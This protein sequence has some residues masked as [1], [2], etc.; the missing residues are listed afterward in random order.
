LH[1]L[2]CLDLAQVD[3]ACGGVVDVPTE[4]SR[5]ELESAARTGSPKLAEAAAAATA[6]E[7]AGRLTQYL[8]GVPALL[9]RY[10]GT[11]G[12]PYG[13]AVITAGIDASRLGHAGLLSEAFLLEAAVG[14]LTE[15]QRTLAI[16]AWGSSA[17]EWACGE[18]KGAVRAVQPMPPP[19]GTGVAGYRVAD[20]LE[21]HGRR[22]RWK[23]RP[24]GKL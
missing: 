3:P 9:D 10:S 22:T 1:Q 8:A 15:S 19:S 12:D 21:Q 6:A 14:Y 23:E 2:A 11:G 18:L 4:F 7:Q 24:C 17:L 20:W 5:A 16:A 13:Q